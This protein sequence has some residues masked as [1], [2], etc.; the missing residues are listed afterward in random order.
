MQQRLTLVIQ[1]EVRY[2]LEDS[3]AAKPIIQARCS[4]TTSP[5]YLED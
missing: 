2:Q 4:Q 1:M 5:A 3:D